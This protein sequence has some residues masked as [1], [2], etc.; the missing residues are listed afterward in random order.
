MR[1][2]LV[3]VARLVC[4]LTGFSGEG[5]IGR[6]IERDF[7]VCFNLGE[8]LSLLGKVKELRRRQVEGRG[9]R[10]VKEGSPRSL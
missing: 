5:M 7:A 3:L 9:S 1:L 6:V 2:R 8:S 4:L 10:R